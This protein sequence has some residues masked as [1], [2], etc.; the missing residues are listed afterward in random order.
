M[1]ERWSIERIISH[2]FS[3][4]LFILPNCAHCGA[5]DGDFS[6][7]HW[8]MT[9]LKS[10]LDKCILKTLLKFND[11]FF[12]MMDFPDELIILVTWSPVIRRVAQV[13][14]RYKLVV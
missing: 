9:D 13:C 14:T 8:L 2:I 3:T 5:Y 6:H 4:F 7:C 1:V 11:G 10:M 12:F